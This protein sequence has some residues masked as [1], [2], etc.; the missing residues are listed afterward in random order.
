MTSEAAR[1]VDQQLRSRDIVDPRVL[2]AM[3]AV[4]RHEFVPF[5]YRSDA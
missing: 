4:P 2:A 3:A 1:M 5:E